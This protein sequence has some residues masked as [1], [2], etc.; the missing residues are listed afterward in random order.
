MFRTYRSQID[1]QFIDIVGRTII[2]DSAPL[3]VYYAGHWLKA[4]VI[5][6][7][8][9][10]GKFVN[11]RYRRRCDILNGLEHSCLLDHVHTL[12]IMPYQYRYADDSQHQ[13]I[14]KYDSRCSGRGIHTSEVTDNLHQTTTQ[15]SWNTLSTVKWDREIPCH[16]MY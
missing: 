15:S 16:H 7:Y 11:I 1:S 3:Q 5:Q 2:I 9:L 12:Y 14:W 8:E 4:T 10:K 13:S 6:L